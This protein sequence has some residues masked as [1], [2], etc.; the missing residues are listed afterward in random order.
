MGASLPAEVPPADGVEGKDF[1]YLVDFGIARAADGTGSLT[2]SGPIV[3]TVDYMAPERF[4]RAA[5]DHRVDVYSL[6]CVMFEAL[7]GMKPFVADSLAGLLYSH[8]N[9]LPLQPS[10]LD[11]TPAS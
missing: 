10:Q 1:A 8:L 4:E 5:T 2:G 7:T 6:A 11:A 9:A 3:G